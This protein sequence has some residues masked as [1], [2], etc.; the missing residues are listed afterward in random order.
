MEIPRI[1]REPSPAERALMYSLEDEELLEI[2]A[3][4]LCEH[5]TG[6]WLPDLPAM[7]REYWRT[8]ALNLM[9]EQ[10]EDEPP[11]APSGGGPQPGSDLPEDTVLQVA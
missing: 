7:Q 2:L 4:N 6:A 10:L 8:A 5:A 11:P 1:G 3:E 9:R